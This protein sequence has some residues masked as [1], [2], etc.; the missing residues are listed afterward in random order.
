MKSTS[1]LPGPGRINVLCLVSSLCVGGAEKHTVTI[2]NLLDPGI[3]KAHLCY[4]KPVDALLGQVREDVRKRTFCLNVK[5][6]IDLSALRRLRDFIVAND[7]HIIIATNEYSALYA[8]L[9]RMMIARTLPIIE[10]FHTTTFAGMKSTLQM[11][12]Y[13]PVFKRCDLLVYVSENQRDYWRNKGLRGIRDTVIHNG[14]DLERFKSLPENSDR[15]ETRRQ[16]GFTDS[17]FIVGICAA[18]RPEKAHV[19]LLESLAHLRS[20]G[21][22]A[23]G[24]FVGDGPERPA[25]ERRMAELNLSSSVY[26]SGF[27]EDVRP[28]VAICDVV[29]LTS[30]SIETFSIAALE[31]MAMS[32]PLVLTRIGGAEEQVIDGKNGFVFDP[33]DIETL[34]DRLTRLGSATVRESMGKA[35]RR[36]V[37]ELFSQ[38][39]MLDLFQTQILELAAAGRRWSTSRS[40]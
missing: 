11:F 9:T 24:L 32:K 28:Y 8:M 37:E 40:L 22:R 6:R 18:L 38:V 7:I 13:R 15:S 20:K 31:G 3:F 19:D 16:C 23:C 30:H 10:V 5:K 25:I 36:R 27:K 26:I 35:S 2:A 39:R 14:V 17:D 29:A 1:G 4:L 12:I 34:N 33:G 21:V